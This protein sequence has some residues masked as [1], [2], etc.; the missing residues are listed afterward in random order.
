MPKTLMEFSHVKRSRLE[1]KPFK[2]GKYL[3]LEKLAAGGMA[4]VY[5]ARA[6]GA[7]GFEKQLAIKRILPNYSSNE[8][9]RRMFENEARLSSMLTHANIVQIYDFVKLGD[10]Y[11]LA[12]EY[13]DGKNLRQFVNKVKKMGYAIPIEFATY[14]INETCKGLEYAHNKR[15]DLTG[16]PLN[17][18]HRDMS[19]QNIMLSYEGAVKIVDFGIAKAKDRVDE[20]RSGV[21][22]GKFGYMSPEQANGFPVDHRTDI[23]STAIIFY[24]LLTNKRLFAADNDLATLK[25]IQ[26]CV[27][28]K[29]SL[30]NPKITSD[31]EKI[32]MKGLTKDL[33]LRYQVSGEFHRQL[34]SFMNRSFPSFTQREVSDILHRVFAS[35]IAGEKRRYEQLHRQSIPFSQGAQIAK[36]T[37]T[38]N[39]FQ[40]VE[41]ALDGTITRS[42]HEANTAI[43]FADE[44]EE[45]LGN[46]KPPSFSASAPSSSASINERTASETQ[47]AQSQTLDST[48]VEPVQDEEAVAGTMVSPPTEDSA[49]LA[50]TQKDESESYNLVQSN[51]HIVPSEIPDTPSIRK[52]SFTE[53]T[54]AEDLMPLLKDRSISKVTNKGFKVERTDNGI[55]AS[56]QSSNRT[57]S[58]AVNLQKPFV[59]SNEERRGSY[60]LVQQVSHTGGPEIPPSVPEG[61]TSGTTGTTGTSGTGVTGVTGGTGGT[62]GQTGKSSS[63]ILVEV[64]KPHAASRRSARPQQ[65]EIEPVRRKSSAIPLFIVFGLIGV[66]VYLYRILLSGDFNQVVKIAPVLEEEAPRQISTKSP[67]TVKEEV[68][69]EES[70]VPTCVLSIDSDPPGALVHIDKNPIGIA[71]QRLSVKCKNSVNVM[72]KREGYETLAENILVSQKEQKYQKSLAR[73]PMGEFE[74]FVDVNA[75]VFVDGQEVGQAIANKPFRVSVRARIKHEVKFVNE[76]FDIEAI[77]ENLVVDDQRKLRKLIK[78][79]DPTKKSPPKKR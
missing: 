2:I 68:A 31:L 4:E 60:S 40:E 69:L 46:E 77:E 1:F 20:T 22:K 71:P 59:K 65:L 61:G 48:R 64:P 42:E 74:F 78:L 79:S 12:M 53:V 29:P 10:T 56:S 51:S 27:I 16:K 28:P 26:E 75:R 58:G 3:L 13:V 43:T 37:D 23:F 11:L 17:I 32:L 34:Q 6:S 9:F 76:V 7:G 25:L 14:L 66:V 73:A 57:D 36:K 70:G 47:D 72:L 19:P 8:E 18:I 44:E 30:I 67:V 63:K 35:E 45:S 52:G 41:N 5:R 55:P 62:G 21:I 33:N 54:E 50:K 39:E 24:E 49:T 38:P 15:D